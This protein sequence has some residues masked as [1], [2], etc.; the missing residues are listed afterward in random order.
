MRQTE[1]TYALRALA[2]LRSDGW[3]LAEVYDGGIRPRPVKTDAEAVEAVEAVEM[4]AISLTHPNYGTATLRLLF[5]NGEPE[6]V[7]YDY[8]ARDLD[9]LDA[10]DNALASL[11]VRAWASPSAD[12]PDD[13]DAEAETA[14]RNR[15]AAPYD[16][17][18]YRRGPEDGEDY[19]IARQHWA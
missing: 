17:G 6:E 7:I 11:P 8:T 10:I 13:T 18:D 16:A 12:T 2:A 19:G 9:A 4:G 5:Q 3:R 1:R 14:A 15:E